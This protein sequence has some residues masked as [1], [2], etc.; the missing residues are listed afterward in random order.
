MHDYCYNFLPHL[1]Q[2][3]KTYS[4]GGNKKQCERCGHVFYT[5]GATPANI[6][7]F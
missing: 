4:D 3:V 2:V 1:W 5:A 7:A 6:W